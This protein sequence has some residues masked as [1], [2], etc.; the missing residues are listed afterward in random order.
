M[1]IELCLGLVVALIQVYNA[2]GIY[3]NFLWTKILILNLNTDFVLCTPNHD[4]TGADNFILKVNDGNSNNKSG[5]SRAFQT[6][7]ISSMIAGIIAGLTRLEKHQEN[8]KSYRTGSDIL[9]K[10]KYF[11]EN[12]VGEYSSLIQVVGKLKT[13]TSDL[14]FSCHLLYTL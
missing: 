10:E 12:N 3:T 8:W 5:K 7:L 14:A 1:I 2:N 4:F 11:F 9:R 13:F 6:R